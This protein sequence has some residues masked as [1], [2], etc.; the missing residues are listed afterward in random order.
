MNWEAERIPASDIVEVE[1]TSRSNHA[2]INITD[3]FTT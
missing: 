3:L 1:L 2:F